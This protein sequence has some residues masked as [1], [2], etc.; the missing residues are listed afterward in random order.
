MNQIPSARRAEPTR[1]IGDPAQSMAVVIC[2]Y[3]QDRWDELVAAVA[4]VR[5]QLLPAREIV[6]VIDHNPPLFAR[7]SAELAGTL[8][9]ENHHEPGLCGGRN[10]GVD[11]TRA[12]IVAFL[13]DDA[14]ADEQWLAALLGEYDEPTT[15]GAGGPVLP[16]WRDDRPP[17]FT[18]EFNWVVGCTWTGMAGPGGAIRN[19]IG[20]NFSVRREVIEAVGGFDARLSRRVTT[21]GV[22]SGTADETEFCI[23]ARRH[24][25]DGAFRFAAAARVHHHV[26]PSRATWRF[27][28]Q[29]C[30]VEGAAKAVLTELA[31]AGP[32]RA[33]ER[34]YVRSVLP[35]AV[36]RELRSGGSAGALRAGSIVVGL[37]YTGGAYARGRLALR[38][39]GPGRRSASG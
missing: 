13:D 7:A 32:G 8:V 19:P 14:V 33:S 5:A 9:V 26:P 1:A 17:W 39:G 3:T 10:T 21:A 36:W 37:A 38:I 11:V 2:A 12:P 28:R 15:L 30:R 23:R 35:R 16:L 29:R 34:R 4:S 18:D 22:M 6:V 25:P 27:Y 20:A 24:R 31:G